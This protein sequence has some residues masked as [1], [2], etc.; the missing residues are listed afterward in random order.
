M[1][2]FAPLSSTGSLQ[3]RALTVPDLTQQMFDANN[4]LCDADPRHG[5]CLT[6]TALFRGHVSTREVDEHM[7]KV[8][9]KTPLHFVEW[10]PINIK[11]SVCDVPSEGLNMA[12]AFIANSTAVQESFKRVGKY[13][14]TLFRCNSFLHLYTSEGMEE[15]EFIAAES[16]VNDLVSEYQ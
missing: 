3:Y 14:T 6:A 8:A 13:F 1:A 5:H 11:A 10:A 12:V 16:N 9:N 2:S 7:L 4:M 15:M